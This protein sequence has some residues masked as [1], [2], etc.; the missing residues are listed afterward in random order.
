[1]KNSDELNYEVILFQLNDNLVAIEIVYLVEILESVA[2]SPLPFVPSYVEGLVNVNGDIMPQVDLSKLLFTSQDTVVE[3]VKS[4]TLL[5]VDIN[6]VPIALKIDQVKES[7]S[8]AKKDLEPVTELKA[9]SKAKNKNTQSSTLKNYV[10]GNFNYL[11]KKVILFDASSL[12]NIVKS[13][14]KPKGKQGFLGKVSQSVIQIEE[15][16]EYLIVDSGGK[17]FAVDLDEVN[18][19]V[20]MD[21]IKPQPRAPKLI[22]GV[23]LV[24]GEPRLMVSLAELLGDKRADVITSGAAIIVKFSDVLCGLLADKMVGLETI[25]KSQVKQNK[26]KTH[27]TILREDGETLTKVIQFSALL[28]DDVMSE[29]RS[30]LPA[31]KSEVEKVAVK[32]I[33]MLRFT[34]N[35]E[36]YAFKL[37]DVRR[38]VSGKV[39]EP[40]LSPTGY[41][42]GTFELEGKVIPVIN[43]IEQLGYEKSEIPIVEYV[44]VTDKGRDWALAIGETDQIIKVDEPQIDIVNK[45]NAHYVSAYSNYE[46]DV[47]T[48][49]NVSTICRDN[50]IAGVA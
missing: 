31:I 5:I 28:K 30:Y 17:E 37:N 4:K 38:V 14:A 23:G 48:V 22:V 27:L 41:I 43:L 13:T 45:K 25:K 11:D 6:D 3:S 47:L 21:I 35:K 46:D 29:M 26:D 24:R 20:I 12:K 9:S 16:N 7:Y 50:T 39:I 8:V 34:L 36:G 10:L 44:V 15:V 33:E 32:Q 2:I 49:L 18:E 19:I 40:V 42:M 1:M